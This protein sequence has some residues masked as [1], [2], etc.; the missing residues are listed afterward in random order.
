MNRVE[1][2]AGAVVLGFGVA[3]LG[4]ALEFP[5]MLQGIPGPGFLPLLISI[6]IV[7]SG[8]VLTAR[9]AMSARA[10]EAA[11]T[12]PSFTGWARVALMLGTLAI[13]FLLLESLGFLVVTTVFMAVMI[14][15]LGERSWV[16]LVVIPVLAAIGLYLVFATWLRVPLPKGIFTFLG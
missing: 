13:S 14:F 8:V 7:A 1:T 15:C 3:L 5:F 6:G 16:K 2:A 12:W 4:G 10:A 9:G 11:I